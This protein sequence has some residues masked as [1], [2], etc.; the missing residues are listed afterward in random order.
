MDII[1]KAK[2]LGQMIGDS[3]EMLNLKESEAEIEQDDRARTLMN[4]YKLLQVELVKATR[5]KRDSAI[6]EE[7]K[8]R[9]VSKQEE[10]NHYDVTARYLTAKKIFDGFMKE[11]NDVIIYSI[12]GEEPCSSGKCSSCGGGC[13]K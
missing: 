11:I 7:I 12:T 10:I 13:S 8:G 9:L 1:Q 4:D 2:E 5:E 6:I 3:E